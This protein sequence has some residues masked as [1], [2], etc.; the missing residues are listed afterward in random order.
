ML[1]GVGQGGFSPKLAF[2]SADAA[3]IGLVEVYGMAKDAK[4]ETT[5]EVIKPSGEVLGS[6]QGTVGAGPSEDIRITYGG[7][8]IATL[9][10]GDYTM[11]ATISVDGRQAGVL[12]R[13]LRKLN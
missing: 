12:T 13:T 2:T 7:F 5:F 8:G 9:E 1:L 3:V 4:L 10:P 11:R 6:G